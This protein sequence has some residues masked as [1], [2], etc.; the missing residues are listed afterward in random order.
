MWPRDALLRFCLYERI[1]H[2]SHFMRRP[3]HASTGRASYF[4]QRVP[5]MIIVQ[6]L[7]PAPVSAP[8]SAPSTRSSVVIRDRVAGGRV[9]PLDA[10]LLDA[11]ARPALLTLRE[12][13]RAGLSVGAAATVPGAPAFVSRWCRVNAL[14]PDFA[15]HPQGYAEGLLSLLDRHPARVLLP[16]SALSVA[17]LQTLRPLLERHTALALPP[18]NALA[19]ALDPE[20]THEHAQLLGIATRRSALVRAW[21]EMAS[22]VRTVG[23]PAV[24]RPLSDTGNGRAFTVHSEDEAWRAAEAL[25]DTGADVIIEQWLPGARESVS[26]LYARDRVWARFAQMA[27]R[28][29]PGR[30][31]SPVECE[32]IAL[33]RDTARHAHRLVRAL[34]LEGFAEVV[35]QRDSEGQPVLIAVL[36][37]LTDSVELAARAGINFP[38]LVF[39]W[40]AQETLWSV[41]EY[42]IGLRLRWLGADLRALTS[43]F[44]RPALPDAPHPIQALGALLHNCLR[45][46]AYSALDWQ[47]PLPTLAAAEH[48]IKR[49]LHRGAGAGAAAHSGDSAPVPTISP[50]ET[51]Q[52]RAAPIG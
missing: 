12:L 44:A 27:R 31:A 18:D 5:A 26:L 35:F 14:L 23:L 40:A 17:H 6:P 46:A 36:P 3:L 4:H 1:S 48:L 43:A 21:N 42:R 22:A 51:V 9:G 41:P 8:N 28:T 33:P 24:V 38:R 10:V 49:A 29:Q 15:T 32:S 7:S 50:D 30:D 52:G 39:A 2:E 16:T 47:D 45:P 11:P 20:R 34:D 13:G 37:H 19:A 25:A